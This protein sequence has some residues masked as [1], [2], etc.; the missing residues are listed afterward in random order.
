MSQE[1]NDFIRKLNF[2]SEGSLQSYSCLKNSSIIFMQHCTPDVTWPFLPLI[3]LDWIAEII[4][5]FCNNSVK[6]HLLRAAWK[7]ALLL[8]RKRTATNMLPMFKNTKEN[9]MRWIFLAFAICWKIFHE[10]YQ[11]YFGKIRN[12]LKFH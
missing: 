7:Q 1:L 4:L 5:H 11:S 12:M 8:C 9:K 10:F 3:A 6:H 2:S